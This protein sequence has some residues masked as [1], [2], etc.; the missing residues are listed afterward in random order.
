MKSIILSCVAFCLSVS[1]VGAH[2]TVGTFTANGKTYIGPQPRSNSNLNSPVR[3]IDTL[4]PIT[5]ANSGSMACGPGAK[6]SAKAV[7]DV[8][9]GSSVSFTW[10]AG[11]SQKWPHRWGPIMLYAYQCPGDAKDCAPPSGAEWFLIDAAGFDDN[12]NEVPAGGDPARS[13]W[14]QDRFRANMSVP[15]R[16]PKSM[17]NGSFLLRHEIIALHVAMD[18]GA[19]FYVSCTQ[20]NVSGGSSKTA[21]DQGAELVKFP[22]AYNPSEKGLRVNVFDNGLNKNNYVMPGPKVF[23]GTGNTDTEPASSSSTAGNDT[24]T[25]T[26]SSTNKPTGTKSGSTSSPTTTRPS[27]CKAKRHVVR[28]GVESRVVHMRSRARRNMID[29]VHS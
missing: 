8:T 24:P 21:K 3:E 17:P 16:I 19:E 14:V 7:A 18:R 28:S 20:V 13:G 22:G 10:T 6:S 11:T 1:L 12:A 29:S 23:L 5:D 15:A 27:R 9:A 2:G 4:N 26:K 25:S